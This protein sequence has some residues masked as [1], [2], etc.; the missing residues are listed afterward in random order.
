ML[1]PTEV[2][3]QALFLVNGDFFGKT[4]AGIYDLT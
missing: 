3:S 2:L 4:G 1:P